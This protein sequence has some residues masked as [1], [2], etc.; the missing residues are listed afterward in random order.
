MRC[1][2]RVELPFSS[3]D[4]LPDKSVI[5]THYRSVTPD[6]SLTKS[7]HTLLDELSEKL[8]PLQTSV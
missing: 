8:L 5:L 2:Y 6:M 7:L 1:H 3:A 4:D